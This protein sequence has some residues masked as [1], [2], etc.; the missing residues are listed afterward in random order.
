MRWLL[1]CALLLSC[2]H[3]AVQPPVGQA[4]NAAT[5]VSG[6]Q[7][8][9]DDQAENHLGTELAELPTTSSLTPAVFE[10]PALIGEFC[11]VE[12][13]VAHT[14]GDERL[15]CKVDRSTARLRWRLA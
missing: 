8:E 7:P 11:T 1:P 12:G 14:S 4:G 13:D 3:V 5:V 15:V 6:T 2:G 9:T 10:G